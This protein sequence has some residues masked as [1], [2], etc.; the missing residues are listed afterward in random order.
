MSQTAPRP[1]A[2]PSA[3]D[4]FVSVRA[5][6]GTGKTYTLTTR[7]IRL[8]ADGAEVGD[9]FAATFARKAAGEIL[10][11]V[12]HRLATAADPAAA[13]AT[14]E[15]AAGIEKPA[16]DCGFF[17]DLLVKVTASLDQLA[18]GTLD[19]FFVTCADASRYELG[20]PA[21]WTIGTDTELEAQ[22]RRA[23]HGTIKRATSH[24]TSTAAAATLADLMVR[25]A[26]G[27]TTTG[28]ESLLE[29]VVNDLASVHREADAA[30]WEWLP[31]PR[32]PAVAEVDA[33]L[34]AIAATAFTDKRI[35]EARDKD[36]E[37]FRAARWNDF[38]AKG[39]AVK[40]LGG[41]DS[42]YRKPIEPALQGAYQ[43][44]L[45]VART[46]V[47]GR[48]AAQTRG[49]REMLDRYA[50]TTDELVAAEGIVSF[51][52]I[53]RMV[54][55][56]AGDGTLDSARWRGI[57]FARHLLLDEFQDTSLA[58]W[59][60]LERLAEHTVTSGGSF[61]AVGD[62]KQAIYGWR[63]GKA[64]LLD[65]LAD[66]FSQ[67]TT[68]LSVQHLSESHRSSPS[69]LDV[70]NRVFGSLGTCVPLADHA[71]LAARWSAGFVPHRAAARKQHL[72]GWVR[73][74]TA[75]AAG[76]DE[77]PADIVLGHAAAR[78]AALARANPG[79][80]IGVLVRTNQAAERV[81]ARL[82]GRENIVA[83]AEGGNPLADSPAVELLLSALTLVDHPSHSIAR[84]HVGTSPLAAQLGLDERTTATPP[85]V[86]T[87]ALD[88]LRRELIDDGYGP[89]LARLAAVVAP[90]GSQRD[91][92][93]LEQFVES[94]RSWDL[95]AGGQRT[96]LLRT[97]DFIAQC[98]GTNV[99]DP[100]PSPIR[101]MTIHKAKGLEFDLV[102]LTDLDRKLVAHQPR[103]VVDRAGPLAPIRR[104][105]SAVPKEFLPFL[106]DDWQQ[107][108]AE[109]VQPV[110][111]EGIATL[112]VGLTRAIQ[113]LEIVIAPSKENEKAV[114]KTLAGILRATL[115]ETPEAAA[116]RVLFTH[117]HAANADSDTL[118]TPPAGTVAVA[119]PAAV[120]T[121]PVVLKALAG[122]V[123]RRGAP[124][125]TPS[126]AEGGRI[127]AALDL[128]DAGSQQAKDVGTLLHAWMEQ[129]GWPADIPGDDLL[130]RIAAEFPGL[131]SQHAK[132]LAEFHEMC[133]RPSV[134]ALLTEPADRLPERFIAR[135]IAAGPA[136]PAL[137][138]EHAFVL[139]DSDG[140]MQGVI[141]RLVLWSRA[142]KPVAAEVIDFKFDGVGGGTEPAAPAR[143]I[144][145]KTAFYAPQLAAY[146]RAVAQLFR[147]APDRI[148][149]DLVFM[150]T[151]AVVPVE[152]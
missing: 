115:P 9:V 98:R 126:S 2:S 143:L 97:D 108:C 7:M 11:R 140:I 84:F 36:L 31:V 103:V 4:P 112:Y 80:R 62:D 47:L 127:M 41:E 152:A 128:L 88:R 59:R 44:L 95:A 61:F 23:I 33:A 87:A 142:G 48:I 10:A 89:V 110:V 138:R 56:A 28:L 94:A 124:L 14:R 148:T 136:E 150:R 132:L 64:E 42:Y 109:A 131:A 122:G 72:P 65:A 134:A 46:A 83:S 8:L 93:R 26:G 40:V 91:V 1:P 34:A 81:I 5:S 55:L 6:A 116:D 22:R 90:S 57:S 27:A 38:A 19:S 66:F 60:V 100:V 25:V 58:Q 32:P 144:A 135:G 107:R 117:A 133:R 151:G 67:A 70:V 77:R 29:G 37:A 111:R 3:P 73:L 119:P 130:L 24:D 50:Q 96:G 141:D 68:P 99:A 69:V 52:D 51:D 102:V 53:T 39:I 78:A 75:P 12:L 129:V 118:L 49:L 145:E 86:C 139:R 18:V 45:A 71:D 54:G 21:N 120:A 101:V 15:L 76:A 104:V 105:L 13:D 92:R 123:R 149:A 106:P 121:T 79:A 16:A 43:T 74:R 146:R 113:G 85:A 63:G 114:P 17:R 125:R 137:R 82:K 35:T 20:L 30:A 147:L